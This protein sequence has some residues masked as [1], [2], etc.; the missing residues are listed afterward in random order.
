MAP[1][2]LGSPAQF[3]DAS[4]QP[5]KPHQVQSLQQLG[6]WCAMQYLLGTP[7]YLS[8]ASLVDQH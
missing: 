8:I 1:S 3:V 4:T 6:P 5:S 7:I 2:G